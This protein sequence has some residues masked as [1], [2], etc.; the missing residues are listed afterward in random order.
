[1]DSILEKIKKAVADLQAKVVGLKSSGGASG[2]AGASGAFGGVQMKVSAKPS[3]RVRST[4]SVTPDN[5]L[6][7][8]LFGEKVSVLKTQGE[9]AQIVWKTSDKG[10]VKSEFLEK[11]VE[12]F[13]YLHFY[14]SGNVVS[15]PC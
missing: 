15:K 6:G 10:W 13:L 5:I 2:G 14:F 7:T 12:N 1:M 3:L 11:F 8:L 9:W 4:P